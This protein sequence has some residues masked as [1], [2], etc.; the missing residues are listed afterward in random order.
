MSK[1]SVT[2]ITY[3]EEKKIANALE[4]VKW[5]DEIIVIDSFSTDHTV[6]ICY[7]YTDKVYQIPWQGYVVQKNLALDKA[8]HEWV[9]NLDADEQVS[10]ELAEEIKEILHTEGFDG[11]YI[12]RRVFY[13]G[14]WIRHAGWYPDYKLRLFKKSLARWEGEGVHEKIILRG[15]VGYLK[16]DLYHF[17]YDNLSHHLQKIN[18]FTT[19][20]AEHSGRRPPQGYTIVL[21]ALFEFFK[22][23]FLKRAFLEG[24]RGLIISGL[25]AFKVFIK[26]AKMWE[27]SQKRECRSQESEAGSQNSESNTYSDL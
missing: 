27:L 1:L 13:L 20:A 10:P 23:F 8:S 7:R 18:R 15:K 6:E 22:K 14:A 11:Y 24:T 25:S 5:A 26:Y 19:I 21:R 4:S 3:N 17:S 16:G 9:L 2:L 12:P